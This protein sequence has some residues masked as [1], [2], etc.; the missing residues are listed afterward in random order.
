MRAKTCI[1][2]LHGLIHPEGESVVCELGIVSCMRAGYKLFS[3]DYLAVIEVVNL[4][5]DSYGEEMQDVV[6]HH[7]IQYRIST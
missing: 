3:L 2:P 5:Y 4:E 6:A 1:L 7:I